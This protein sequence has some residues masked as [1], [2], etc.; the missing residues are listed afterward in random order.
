M[1]SL[2]FAQPK[3]DERKA[4]APQP[5]PPA[6]KPSQRLR[7]QVTPG[8]ASQWLE[9]NLHNRPLS[10]SLVIAYGLDM[11]EGRW[12]YNG[13]AIRFDTEGQLIDGQ[14]RLHACIEA[15]VPFETD[16]I[17][18]LDPTAIRTIDIG[19]ARTAG[20]I[21]HLEGAPN[22]ASACA[23]AAM[24]ILHRR[25]G[26]QH[27]HDCRCQPTKP[28]VVEA[29]R[30][31]PAL[32]GAVA[33]ARLLG[34]KIAPPRVVGFCYYEFAARNREL[35]DRFFT[36]LAHGI[37]LTRENP[38]YH[39]RERLLADRQAKAKLPQL[40]IVALFFKAWLYYRENRPMRKLFWKSDGPA[41]ER[42]PDIG[43][44]A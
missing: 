27:L 38:V 40:E 5:A 21:A 1:T 8:L 36:E 6:T 15:K 37:N 23:V 17:F 12:Q 42:F 35:A 7:M 3:Q 13:D 28:Q 9:Q 2:H 44:V 31:M 30:S 26:I 10:D 19:K 4:A 24:I 20:H 29:V 32:E 11:I 18:G 34:K 43:E 33:Q 41:P 22:A 25:H 16:V 39:L 14:H